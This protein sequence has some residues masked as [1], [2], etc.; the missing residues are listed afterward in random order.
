MKD[1][2]V[3]IGFVDSQIARSD[4]GY[5]VAIIDCITM[6]IIIV[7]LVIV[8]KYKVKNM[9]DFIKS[10]TFIRDFTLHLDGLEIPKEDIKKEFNNLIEHF[11]MV[12]K[13]DDEDLDIFNF[14]SISLKHH[15]QYEDYDKVIQPKFDTRNFF[16]YDMV[17]PI[18][19]SSKLGAINDFNELQEEVNQLKSELEKLNNSSTSQGLEHNYG[20]IESQGNQKEKPLGQDMENG[21][22]IYKQSNPDGPDNEIVNNIDDDTQRNKGNKSDTEQKIL[23]LKEQLEEKQR[24]MDEIKIKIIEKSDIT[25][26]KEVYITF[27]NNNIYAKINYMCQ[28]LWQW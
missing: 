8:Q 10:R 27:R 19:T 17:Y 4:L 14:E 21:P 1:N 13:H 11:T 26:V 16:I 12:A 22:I 24:E 3:K 7:T 5:L 23:K 15:P 20:P 9:E 6:I 25:D 2:L 18:L 28:L